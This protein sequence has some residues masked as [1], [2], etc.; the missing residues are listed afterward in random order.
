MLP[1]VEIAAAYIIG[2]M[3]VGPNLIQTEYLNEDKQIVTVTEVIQEV[4]N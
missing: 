4:P 2:M 3:Q 1:M